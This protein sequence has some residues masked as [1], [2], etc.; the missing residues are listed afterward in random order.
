MKIQL[1]QTAKW[2]DSDVE[3]VIG[4]YLGRVGGGDG[5]L[6]ES[7]EVDGRWGRFSLAAGN[8]LLLAACEGGKLKLTL[9]D[10]RLAPLAE[11][12]GRPY[13]EGLKALMGDLELVPENSPGPLPPITRALYGYLG[14]GA[15]RPESSSNEGIFGLPGRVYLF[16]HAYNQLLE[17]SLGGTELPLKKPVDGQASVGE[18]RSSFSHETFM[19]AAGN[20]VERLRKGEAGRMTLSAQY[21]APFTGD[22]FSVYRR[23]RRLEPSPYMFFQRMADIELAVSSPEVMVSCDQGRL[24]LSPTTGSRPLR[25]DLAEDS[26]FEDIGEQDSGQKTEHALMVEQARNDLAKVATFGTV[27]MERFMEI[28][29]FADSVCLAS[30]LSAELRKGLDATDMIKA[31][32]PAGAASGT[33]R[34][35]AMPLIE[36]YENVPRGPYGGAL[37]WLGLDKDSVSFDLGVTVRGLW[38]RGGNIFWNTGS[39]L[40]PGSD[41]E[42]E[43]RELGRKSAAALK[44]LGSQ[45]EE[46]RPPAKAETPAAQNVQPAQEKPPVRLPDLLDIVA[47]LENLDRE[48]A[49]LLFSRLMDGELNNSQAGALLM[50]LRAKGETPVEMAEAALAVLSRAVQ[51][52]PL[53]GPILDIVGTGGD[54]R[55]S[56]N[57]STATALVMSGLGYKVVK[58]GNR[59][60]SSRSGSADV[61]ELL[62]AD[63]NLPPEQVPAELEK[64]NFAFLFAPSYHPAFRHI[65]PVRKELGI[66]TLFNILGPLVNPAHPEHSFLGAPNP[67]FLPLM[68]GALARLGTGF[69]AIVHGAGGYDEVTTMGPASVFI[70]DGDKISETSVDPARYGFTPSR[71][72]ELAISGPGEG[73]AVLRE[74]LN[75]KGP[76]PMRDMLIMNVAMALYVRKGGQDFDGCVALAREAVRDGAGRN[77]FPEG[78]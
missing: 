52:P 62:G 30:R 46:T 66:R 48:K 26:L 33:P 72:E 35:K 11:Y 76:A 58:H 17:L 57:C 50:G 31:A 5:I 41:P 67:A 9:N 61:L 56:F 13:L 27:K 77:V 63:L 4:L 47:S 70:V 64:R 69:S 74:L 25:G 18:I 28:E 15:G 1:K 37:G 43:W 38:T 59:S 22:L 65:M 23:L 8:F 42:R 12:S 34:E 49:A 29:R 75:G 7:A 55:N 39:D 3:T 36:E 73:V 53:P 54:G 51:L 45:K 20:I 10:E 2:L 14:Y 78:A 6:L 44:T 21:A 32:L 68:A 40:L 16:D 19:A 71:P 24:K 60:I